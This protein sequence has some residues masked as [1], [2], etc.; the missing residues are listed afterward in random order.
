MNSNFKNIAKAGLAVIAL[1]FVLASCKKDANVAKL[2]TVNEQAAATTNVTGTVY[3]HYGNP[4]VFPPTGYATLYL[5]LTG[6]PTTDTSSTAGSRVL[7]LVSYNN[8]FAQAVDTTKYK[9]YY[10]YNTSKT[11]STLKIT[12]FTTSGIAKASIGQATTST[13]N[14]GWYTYDVANPN[15]PILVAGFFIGVV[16]KTGLLPSYAVKFNSV[17]GDGGPTANRG[18]YVIQYGTLNNL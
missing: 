8:S 18:I 13:S 16:S 4:T 1:S 7:K 6:T 15:H 11:W 2:N 14:D 10:Y 9:L 12:D 17:S 3:G 5:G